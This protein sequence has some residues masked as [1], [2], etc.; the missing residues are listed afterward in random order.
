MP[1]LAQICYITLPNGIDGT[2]FPLPTANGVNGNYWTFIA[3]DTDQ[4]NPM[5]VSMTYSGTTVYGGYVT[6]SGV[7]AAVLPQLPWNRKARVISMCR[8]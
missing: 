4:S 7:D 6:G 5:N 8:R 3:D 1:S 2:C